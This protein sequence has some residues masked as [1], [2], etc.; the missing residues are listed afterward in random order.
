MDAVNTEVLV[1]PDVE[2]PMVLDSPEEREKREGI[3]ERIKAEIG[4]EDRERVFQAEER[5]DAP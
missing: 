4:H 2:I 3:H 1:A 5:L